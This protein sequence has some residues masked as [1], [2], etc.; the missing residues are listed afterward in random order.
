[1]PQPTAKTGRPRVVIGDAD[2]RAV[3][4]LQEA[5]LAMLRHPAAA[6][7]AFRALIAEGRR[8]AAT[9]EGRRWK[10]RLARSELVRRG[11]AMWESSAFGMLEE[12]GN[13]PLPSAFLDALVQALASPRWTDLATRLTPFR[14]AE[15]SDADS[16]SGHV[17]L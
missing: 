15:E 17:G 8:F 9:A 10:A 16:P 5:Q 6:Q 7:A 13:S 1:M 12:N 11:R 14:D 3:E 2:D 4:I